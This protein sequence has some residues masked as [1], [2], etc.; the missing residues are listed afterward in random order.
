MRG[1]SGQ[2]VLA[3]GAPAVITPAVFLLSYRW[4]PKWLFPV[5]LAAPLL[6]VFASDVRRGRDARAVAAALTW[7]LALAL[8]ATAVS[9]HQ[10]MDAE[11]AIWNA[12]PYAEKTLRWVRLGEGEE[13]DPS[14]FLPRHAVELVVFSGLALATG[15]AGA[16]VLGAAL[17]NYM[18]FY[19]AALWRLSSGTPLAL[20]LG[21]PPWALVR[22]AAYVALGTALARPLLVQ[23]LPPGPERPRLS[24]PLLAAGLAGVVLD[25]LLKGLLAASWRQILLPWAGGSP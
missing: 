5:L 25:V 21:W 2:A 22:V 11:R 10:P 8:C 18:S 6:P 17:M 24:R 1:S 19:V 20:L 12:R 15:G 4:A 9:M 13:G 7:A 14:R 16:L 23:G 3:I